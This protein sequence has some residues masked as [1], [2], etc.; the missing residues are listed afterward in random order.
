LFTKSPDISAFW[1][2]L[3]ILWQLRKTFK[4]DMI[5]WIRESSKLQNRLT[6]VDH[7][8]S[9]LWFLLILKTSVGYH[10]L[11]PTFLCSSMLFICSTLVLYIGPILCVLRAQLR[12]NPNQFSTEHNWSGVIHLISC[13]TVSTVAIWTM[14]TALRYRN[15]EIALQYR[16]GEI[17]SGN[18]PRM[19]SWSS[20]TLPFLCLYENI[21]DMKLHIF[22]H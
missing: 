11:A 22:V 17:G 4:F 9:K 7:S 19:F 18:W 5:V 2:P 13:W 14:E 16:N 3:Q 12:Q 8:K 15:G 1:W 10:I 6:Y 20:W 21:K